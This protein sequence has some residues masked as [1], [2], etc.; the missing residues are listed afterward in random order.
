MKRYLTIALLVAASSSA[1]HKERDRNS[2][3]TAAAANSM[4][5]SAA[6]PAADN[7]A[8]NDMM[9][10]DFDAGMTPTADNAGTSPADIDTAKKIRAAIVDDKSLSVNAHN[11]KVVVQNGIVTLV[12]PVADQDERTKVERIA[13][14]I[15]DDRNVVNKLE[16][17]K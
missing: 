6:K 11:C 14:S 7:T 16:A 3:L 10:N 15:V 13:A 2:Q 8:R 1:C 12:G 9:N 17:T 5:M 4:A